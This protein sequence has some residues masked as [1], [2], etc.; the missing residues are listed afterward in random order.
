MATLYKN[1]GIYYLGVFYNGKQKAKSLGT[2]DK[3]VS[4]Q[5][6]PNVE[7]AI[8]LE[9]MG[10]SPECIKFSFPELSKRFLKG[11]KHWSKTTYA[12]NESILRLHIAGKPLP[13]NP[14]SRSV[15]VRHINQ[16]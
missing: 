5:L 4:T 1:N 2:K 6:K 14:T 13:T 8:I 7:K 10:I 12:I 15:Y 11:N 16:C 3:L 9:L